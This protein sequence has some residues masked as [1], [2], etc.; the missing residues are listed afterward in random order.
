MTEKRNIKERRF[1]AEYA[2]DENGTRA[3]IAAGYAR[4]SAAVTASR[5]LKKAN[6][7]AEIERLTA[8]TLGKLEISRERVLTEIARMALLDPKEIAQFPMNGPSD[9]ADLSEDARRCIVGWGWDVKGRFELKLASK[10]TAL[11]QLG[12]HLKL[13]T[14]KAEVSGPDGGAVEIEDVKA[15]LLAKLVGCT[16][17]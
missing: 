17:S 4:K 13:F 10:H 3:A 8:T 14:D 2:T 7:R 1:C 9:I 15:K 16:R 12:R 5:L 6:V 11:E